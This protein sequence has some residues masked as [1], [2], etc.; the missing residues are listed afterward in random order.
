[1]IFNCYGIEL[2]TTSDRFYTND[3]KYVRKLNNLIEF[4]SNDNNIEILDFRGR[5]L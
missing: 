1:M 5:S 3:I 2:I 4:I